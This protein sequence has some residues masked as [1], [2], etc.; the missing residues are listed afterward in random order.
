MRALVHMSDGSRA[1]RSGMELID[2]NPASIVLCSADQ[3]LPNM[4]QTD[5]AEVQQFLAHG[6]AAESVLASTSAPSTETAA[7]CG[8]ALPETRCSL[9]QL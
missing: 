6:D 9:R 1:L 5:L 2:L 3:M 8:S 4:T 7:R